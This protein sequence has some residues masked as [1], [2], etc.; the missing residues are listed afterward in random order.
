MFG[1]VGLLFEYRTVLRC[2]LFI[3]SFIFFIYTRRT[4]EV[5]LIFNAA[6]FTRNGNEQHKQ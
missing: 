3:H 5:A 6:E 4:V 1:L 2:R